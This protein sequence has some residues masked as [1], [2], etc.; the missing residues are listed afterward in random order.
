MR[1]EGP[2]AKIRRT[3]ELHEPEEPPAACESCAKPI[4]GGLLARKTLYT[5]FYGFVDGYVRA[6]GT[7]AKRT[8]KKEK[9]RTRKVSPT[10]H[11]GVPCEEMSVPWVT[12]KMAPRH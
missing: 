8:E 10:I 2:P 6:P 11:A 4:A 12:S 3:K 5:F 9:T 7:K 1:I